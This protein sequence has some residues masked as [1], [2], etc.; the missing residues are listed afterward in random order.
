MVPGVSTDVR[1]VGLPVA[2]V[3]V[4]PSVLRRSIADDAYLSVNRFHKSATSRGIKVYPIPVIEMEQRCAII[5]LES[6]VRVCL[7]IIF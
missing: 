7:R 1:R 3:K 2:L 4:G 6:M 5:S